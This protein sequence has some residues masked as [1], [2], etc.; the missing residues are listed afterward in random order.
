MIL[1]DLASKHVRLR[2]SGVKYFGP[3]PLCGGDANSSTRFVVYPDDTFHCFA[4]EF[5]GGTV[6]FLMQVEGMGCLSAHEALGLDCDPSSCRVSD[7]CQR[8]RGDQPR[9]VTRPQ[10]VKPSGH[11]HRSKFVPSAATSPA[12]LWREKAVKLIDYAHEKLIACSD[13]LEYLAGRGLPI[14]AVKQFRLGWISEDLYR[15]RSSWGL[16]ETFRADGKPKKLWI[17]GGIVIPFFDE[18][19]H[20]MRIRIRRPKVKDGE[21]RYYWVPG[22][23]DDVPV[24]GRESKAYVVVE[25]DLDACLVRWQA[26]DM[27]GAVP[28]GTCSAKPKEKAMQVLNSALSILVS[29]DNDAAGVNASDWWLKAF[30]RAKRWPVPAG[31]DPGE[32]FQDHGGNIREWIL[33]GLPPV[34]HLD[35]Q[36]PEV[37]PVPK[38][39]E[40]IK[41]APVPEPVRGMHITADGREIPFIIVS[42]LGQHRQMTEENPGS[43]VVGRK[44]MGMIDPEVTDWVLTVK[45]MFQ[46]CVVKSC[47]FLS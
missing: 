23:G 16:P 44:E 32:F 22:S 15:Q 1:F 35:I 24:L 47:E 39:A 21:C 25:S 38:P 6:K 26:G 28:M 2:Q 46:G 7:R 11:D 12:D 18:E 29:L 36:T 13:Q 5:H 19:N 45:A 17:P 34:F 27:V 20:P 30:Q 40:K 4:C 42:T 37:K 10:S 41:L 43:A 9:P 14:E 33:A 31:K 3:C 8:G